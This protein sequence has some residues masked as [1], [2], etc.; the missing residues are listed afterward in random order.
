[1]VPVAGCRV[2][3]APHAVV[4]LLFLYVR[5]CALRTGAGVNDNRF[6]VVSHLGHLLKAGDLVMGYDLSRAVFADVDPDMKLEL[7]P[8]V[9]LVKKVFHRDASRKRAWKLKKLA[10][11]GGEAGRAGG[12]SSAHDDAEAQ[13]YEDFLQ[14][15]ER[16]KTL[17][18]NIAVFK[19]AC[20]P[21]ATRKVPSCLV[22]FWCPVC[23]LGEGGRRGGV[24]VSPRGRAPPLSL[25]RACSR[26]PRHASSVALCFPSSP[27]CATFVG[28]AFACT[29]SDLQGPCCGGGQG[30]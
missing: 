20:L 26:W 15:V 16:D 24:R 25:S 29:P 14:D 3:C 19:G 18:A 10:T 8:D 12:G 21:R 30:G 11:S 2:R 17:R 5:P 23:V 22:V 6:T 1:M 28:P 7:F 4:A 9:V 27:T 13:Q